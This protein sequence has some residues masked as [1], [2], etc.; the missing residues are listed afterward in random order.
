MTLNLKNPLAFFDL[1]TTGLD[2]IEDRIVEIAIIKVMPDGT[3]SRYVKRVNPERPISEE[4]IGVHGITEEDVK[5]APTFKQIAKECAQF[6]KGADLAGFNILRFDLPMLV[7][8]FLRVGVEFD[9]A[10]K[11]VIDLQR[12]FHLMEPRNLAAALSFYCGDS[13]ENAHSAEADTAA[14]VSILDA[15]VERYAGREI[16]NKEGQPWTPIQ[17]DMDSLH[18]LTLDNKLDLAGR[19]VKNDKG[20]PCF[21]FGK[22]KGQSVFKVLQRDPSYYD[23]MMRAKFAQNTKNVLTQ[24]KLSLLKK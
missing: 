3:E 16:K 9:P 7:E 1:E 24:L 5:D 6:L 13:L 14:C 23:W 17:N 18:A 22:Y 11:R 21:N 12:I 20:E 2:I 4:S 15:Q 19:I 8:E 10:K